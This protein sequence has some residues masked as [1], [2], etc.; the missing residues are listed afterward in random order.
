V[1]FPDPYKHGIEVSATAK[2]L[3]KKLL[4]KNKKKRLGAQG[5]VAEILAHPFFHGLDIEKL[6]KKELTPPYMP[7]ISDDLKYFDQKL[8]C[9]EDFAESMIDDTN[10]KLISQ[11]AGIFK[12]L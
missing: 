5:D 3:I 4:D 10:L 9:R 2:D 12:D 8:T 11:N 1:N 7:E 6:T